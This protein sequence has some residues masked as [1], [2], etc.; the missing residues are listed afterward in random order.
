M[1]PPT[2]VVT[3]GSSVILPRTCP[4]SGTGLATP[5]QGSRTAS[6]E[7]AERAPRPSLVDVLV[8]IF[9]AHIKYFKGITNIVPLLSAATGIDV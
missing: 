6:P 2:A 7:A 8:P 9:A 4:W 5:V 1:S 3:H